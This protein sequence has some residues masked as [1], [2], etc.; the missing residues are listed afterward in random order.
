MMKPPETKFLFI[1]A[2]YAATVKR[3]SRAGENK[4]DIENARGCDR[5]NYII[6]T[7]R[8]CLRLRPARIF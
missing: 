4:P 8:V 6:F 1:V 7:A 3:R 2:E 5:I